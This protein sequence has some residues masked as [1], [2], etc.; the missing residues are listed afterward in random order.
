MFRFVFPCAIGA[1]LLLG[2]NTNLWAQPGVPKTARLPAPGATPVDDPTLKANSFEAGK[3]V[4]VKNDI[5]LPLPLS[6]GEKE[7][8]LDGIDKHIAD[9]VARLQEKMKGA[10][11]DEIAVLAKTNGWKAEEQQKLLSA[12][13]ALDPPGVFSAWSTAAPGETAVAEL[14]SRQTDARRI[15]AKLEQDA[16]N[17]QSAL[18]QD[19]RDLETALGKI[20]VGTPAVGELT[21]FVTELKTWIEA[22]NL[23]DAAVPGQGT[24]AE[25]PKGKINLIYDPSLAPTQ[26][27]VLN[28]ESMLIG[29]KGNG[30]LTIK[31]G[32]AAEALGLPIVTGEPLADASREP[33]TTGIMLVNNH[34][35]RGTLSYM[36]DGFKYDIEPGMVQRMPDDQKVKVVFDRGGGFGVANYDVTPGTYA[37]TPTDEGWQLFQERYD[38]VLD[39]SLNKQEFNFVYNGKNEKIPAGATRTIASFYP[40]VIGYDRG[41]GTDYAIKSIDFSGNVQI[42]VNATDNMWDL[43]PTTD[44]QREKAKLKL[45]E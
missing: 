40:I 42:G 38:A 33:M 3:A 35:T 1:M 29:N 19:A 10:L 2:L 39:N 25:L 21:P 41:N 24:T 32:N 16:E 43:F 22:R 20:S 12:L 23:V 17:K 6:A 26:A 11:P 30:P 36:V 15:M 7:V 8:A 44:N 13:R 9:H 4:A 5:V 14:M 27:I 37:F 31:K 45:F 28:N 34:G 18:S